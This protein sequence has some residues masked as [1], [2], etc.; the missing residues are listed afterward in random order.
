MG[1]VEVVLCLAAGF[2]LTRLVGDAHMQHAAMSW[3][4]ITVECMLFLGMTRDGF[5]ALYRFLTGQ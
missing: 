3:A 5:A 2:L 4:K 1:F